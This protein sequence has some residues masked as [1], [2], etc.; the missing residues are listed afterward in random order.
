MRMPSSCDGF[1][2][3][4]QVRTINNTPFKLLERGLEVGSHVH[5]GLGT[6]DDESAVNQGSLG[7]SS[8]RVRTTY[9]MRTC[10]LKIV[11]ALTSY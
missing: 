8:S 2:P 4:N 1:L 6:Y 7:P 10:L 5:V 9:V 11:K 3:C